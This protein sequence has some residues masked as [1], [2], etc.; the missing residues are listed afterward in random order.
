MLSDEQCFQGKYFL[1]LYKDSLLCAEQTSKK[2]EILSFH[3]Q[4]YQNLS[5]SVSQSQISFDVKGHIQRTA[6]TRSSYYYRLFELC[7]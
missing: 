7:E 5:E 1:S 4:F 3:K 6:S 2:L